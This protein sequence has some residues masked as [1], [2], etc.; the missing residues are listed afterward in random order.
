M[1]ASGVGGWWLELTLVGGKRWQQLPEFTDNSKTMGER[2]KG[3]KK[4]ES[5]WLCLVE[6][7]FELIISACRICNLQKEVFC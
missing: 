4:E 2:K 1:V 6:N 3:E 7:F 5:V